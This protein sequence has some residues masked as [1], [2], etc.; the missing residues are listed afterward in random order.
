[1]AKVS[2]DRLAKT[3]AGDPAELNVNIITGNG[4]NLVELKAPPAAGGYVAQPRDGL[5]S[6]IQLAQPN[7]S[8]LV[9]V[10]RTATA[11]LQK[12][13]LLPGADF[14]SDAVLVTWYHFEG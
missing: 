4:T 8:N 14:Q 7:G 12:G 6:V 3:A 5:V 9:P 13:S 10:D 11:S 1:M 2:A